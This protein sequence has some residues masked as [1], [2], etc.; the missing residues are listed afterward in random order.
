MQL[1]FVKMHGSGNEILVV[2]ERNSQREPPSP[3]VLVQ[4]A[5]RRGLACERL[6]RQHL[7]VGQG[8]TQREFY[9]SMT[10]TTAITMKT[11]IGL[12][13]NTTARRLSNIA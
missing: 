11:A 9:S 1:R 4:A 8:S 12:S 10:T 2:D 6:G 5:K 3:A 13:K 7:R